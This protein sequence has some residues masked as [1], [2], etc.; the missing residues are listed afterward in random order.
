MRDELTKIESTL[1][2][3]KKVVE[4]PK[5]KKVFPVGTAKRYTDMIEALSIGDFG[6]EAFEFYGDLFRK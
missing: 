4:L 6:I 5:G 2:S 3:Y 1:Q